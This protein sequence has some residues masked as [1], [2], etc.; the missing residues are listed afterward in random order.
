MAWSEGAG[1]GQRSKCLKLSLVPISSSFLYC[2][3]WPPSTQAVTCLHWSPQICCGHGH[4]PCRQDEPSLSA[5][6]AGG[7]DRGVQV[8]AGAWVLWC[9]DLLDAG[10]GVFR[11]GACMLGSSFQI[12]EACWWWGLLVGADCIELK[13]CFTPHCLCMPICYA[14]HTNLCLCPDNVITA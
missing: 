14:C 12:A 6:L 9:K 2:H 3:A 11:W 1:W 10:T 13:P 8:G 4:R 7:R 5:T